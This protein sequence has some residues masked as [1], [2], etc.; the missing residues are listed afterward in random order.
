MMELSGTEGEW[1]DE[2]AKWDLDVYYFSIMKNWHPVLM[3]WSRQKAHRFG[4][5]RMSEEFGQIIFLKANKE[6]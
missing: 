2:E 3:K 6:Q 1:G 4:S 5:L